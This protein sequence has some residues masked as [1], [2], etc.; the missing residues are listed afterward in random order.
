ML[1]L[2]AQ[3]VDDETLKVK[4]YVAKDSNYIEILLIINFLIDLIIKN[5]NIEEKELL[6]LIIKMRKEG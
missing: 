1:K 3:M 6:K 5:A 4:K 2:K